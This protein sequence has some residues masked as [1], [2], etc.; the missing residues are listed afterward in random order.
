MV[1]LVID[2]RKAIWHIV[3][4]TAAKGG[5]LSQLSRK[6]PPSSLHLESKGWSGAEFRS[7]VN[8]EHDVT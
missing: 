4:E 8:S 3:D 2:Q 7:Y 6:S 5:E 1:I